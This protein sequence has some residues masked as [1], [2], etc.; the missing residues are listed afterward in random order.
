MRY[1]G[2]AHPADDGPRQDVRPQQAHS[3]ERGDAGES[4]SNDTENVR[5]YLGSF[6]PLSRAG[7]NLLPLSQKQSAQ[8]ALNG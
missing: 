2:S 5:G 8:P 6:V 1:Q 7:H 3:R 4:R